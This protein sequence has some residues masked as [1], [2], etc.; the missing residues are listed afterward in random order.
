LLLNSPNF[1]TVFPIPK[2]RKKENS[3]SLLRE[4]KKEHAQRDS[5]AQTNKRPRAFSRSD[6][7]KTIARG[8]TRGRE[9][10]L[11]DIFALLQYLGFRDPSRPAKI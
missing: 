6:A 9:S 10:A 1:T 5:Q 3:I 2:E 11:S 7:I 8:L 4:W